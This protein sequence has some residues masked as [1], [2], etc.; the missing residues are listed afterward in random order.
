MS[1]HRSSVAADTENA[2]RSFFGGVSTAMRRALLPCSATGGGRLR[3]T[4]DRS[5]DLGNARHGVACGEPQV[6]DVLTGC[7]GVECFEVEGDVF[8]GV[9]S[10]HD[11]AGL[12]AGH[13]EHDPAK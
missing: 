11:G 3:R 10:A 2:S 5:A 6:P 8:A 13:G 4:F 1:V 7:P 9:A 12:F